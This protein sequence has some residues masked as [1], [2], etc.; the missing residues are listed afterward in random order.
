MIGSQFETKWTQKDK[1]KIQN[2][3]RYIVLSSN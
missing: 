2:R 1:Y 3:E